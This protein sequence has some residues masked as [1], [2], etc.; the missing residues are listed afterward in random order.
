MLVQV[1]ATPPFWPKVVT[2]TSQVHYLALFTPCPFFRNG[3][4]DCYDPTLESTVAISTFIPTPCQTS[5]IPFDLE[6]AA[7]HAFFLYFLFDYRMNH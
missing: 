6:K 7:L 4:W 1:L 3:Y 2:N 5:C